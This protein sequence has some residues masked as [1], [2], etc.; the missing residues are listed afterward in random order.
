MA[1]VLIPAALPVVLS[2][3]P[4]RHGISKRS[5]LRDVVDDVSLATA[6]LLFGFTL[7][8]HQA[9]L[10][11]DAIGRTLARLVFTR[12]N[13]LEWRTAAQAKASRH[14]RLAGFFRQMVGGTAVAVVAGVLV[15]VAGKSGV[16]SIAAPFIVMWL[17]SPIV[18]RV[19]SVPVSELANGELSSDDVE[20]LRL[21]ARRTWLFFE[22]FVDKEDNWLP[23]DNFQDDPKPVIEH[24]TSPTNIGMYLLA[25]ITARDFG[26]IGTL[27]MVERLEQTLETLG[28]LELFR[29]HLYNWYDTRDLRQLEPAYVSSVDSGNL[30]GHL[31]TLSNAC[32][33][34]I[35]QPLPV[36]AA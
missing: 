36:A 23:P 14:L 35:D 21:T 16:A 27:D 32:R 29:G 24:R 33:Q 1:T 20:T 5:H 17:L 8:A 25:A 10:M 34:M 31:L 28:K 4:R 7:L 12:R 19:V 9:W 11:I 2:L 13:L 3:L 22:T 6:H 15:L 30:A 18:A 26:W